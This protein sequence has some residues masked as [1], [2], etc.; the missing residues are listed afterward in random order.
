VDGWTAA[1]RQENGED[2]MVTMDQLGEWEAW[3]KEGKVR[4]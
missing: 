1:F 4:P 3:C 2:A